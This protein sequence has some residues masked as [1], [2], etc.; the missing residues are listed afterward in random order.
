MPVSSVPVSEPGTNGIELAHDARPSS[1]VAARSAKHSRARS[2]H[3]RQDAKAAATGESVR[4]E[5]ETPALIRP[6]QNCHRRPPNDARL[7]P[8]TTH[9]Q[10]F[11][12]RRNSVSKTASIIGDHASKKASGLEFIAETSYGAILNAAKPQISQDRPARSLE[13]AHVAGQRPN[14]RRNWLKNVRSRR[15]ARMAGTKNSRR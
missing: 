15:I 6:L 11:P 8:A 12:K 3:D 5:V 14:L 7:A 13:L 4:Q 10:P 1:E 2:L 9:L